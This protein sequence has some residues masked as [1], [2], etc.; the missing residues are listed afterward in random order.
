[1]WW[2]TVLDASGQKLSHNKGE[3]LT[4]YLSR[5]ILYPL[6]ERRSSKSAVEYPRSDRA[7]QT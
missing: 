2:I 3:S 5:L 6:A 1:V 7:Q 4:N